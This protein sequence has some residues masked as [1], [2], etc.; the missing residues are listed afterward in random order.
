MSEHKFLV[1]QSVQFSPDWLLDE[2]TEG[3]YTIVRLFP[4][5]GN[6]PQYRIKS[7][8]DGHERMVLEDHLD[9]L[10]GPA[11]AKQR[12]AVAQRQALGTAKSDVSDQY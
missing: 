7:E 8:R 5:V 9:R 10:D 6:T 3:Q 1:G 12:F 4:K 2:T 11:T